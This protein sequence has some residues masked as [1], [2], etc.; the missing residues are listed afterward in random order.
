MNRRH[1]VLFKG[2]IKWYVWSLLLFC[3]PGKVLADND[4]HRLSTWVEND[5]LHIEFWINVSSCRV[6]PARSFTFT[7]VLRGTNYLRQ[8]PPVVLS[9]GRRYRFDKREK[10][11]DPDIVFVQ[12]YIRYV[13]R[14]ADRID[15]VYFRYALPYEADMEQASFVMMRESK[16]CCKLD[17]LGIDLIAANVMHPDTESDVKKIENTGCTPCIPCI[18]MVSYLPP[19]LERIKQRWKEEVIRIDYPVNGFD[20]HPDFMQN[21]KELA[22][23][24]SL[25][26]SS[27]LAE[28]SAIHIHGYASPEGPYA[29]NEMLASNRARCFSDYM[30]EKY[31]LPSQVFTVKW[32]PEDWEGL[33]AMLRTEQP[34]HYQEVIDII[35]T[36]G[37]FNGR[38]RLLMQLHGGKVYMRLKQKQL[39]MLRRI[40]VKVNYNVRDVSIEETAQL[41]HTAPSM[42]SLQE[43]YRL[44]WVYGPG[45]DE[46]REVY[47]IAAKQYPD[48]PVANINASSAIIMSGDFKQAH[49]YLDHLKEDFRAWNNL[50]VLAMMEGDCEEAEYWFRKA[51]QVEPKRALENLYKLKGEQK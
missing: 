39:M 41:L 2:A 13:G 33:V 27:D 34:P 38:E 28:I 25:M 48:D 45:T 43:M 16:D 49:K 37:T 46:Y 30:M 22:K 42:L 7:P 18:P 8:L 1:S 31:R 26:P 44:A 23:L 20:V 11:L 3:L 32:T 4:V 10:H 36:N 19:R 14:K 12:P 50:G 51:L 17:L 9:G 15:S 24:D 6:T 5:S 35:R 29:N 40:V 47:E 21:A